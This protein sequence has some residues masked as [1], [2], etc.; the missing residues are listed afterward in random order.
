MRYF[1]RLHFLAVREWLRKYT[2]RFARMAVKK[3]G[4]EANCFNFA[5]LEQVVGNG[6]SEVVKQIAEAFDAGK[7]ICYRVK[8]W[9]WYRE[10]NP[11]IK[12]LLVRIRA[13]AGS[14]A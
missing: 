11:Q 10:A 13:T 3:A 1:R 8:E 4:K 12:E 2:R 6:L 9:L 7:R 14:H 5:H